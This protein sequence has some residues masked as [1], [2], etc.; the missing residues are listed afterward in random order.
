MAARHARKPT[1]TYVRVGEEEGANRQA[2]PHHAV[3][4]FVPAIGFAIPFAAMK[5]PARPPL[6]IKMQ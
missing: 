1:I 5:P 4:I 2:I 6:V 3:A